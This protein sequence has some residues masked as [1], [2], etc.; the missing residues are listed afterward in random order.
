MGI[1]E[2]REREKLIRRDQILDAALNVFQKYGWSESTMDQV[3]DEAELAKGTLYLYFKDKEEIYAGL[4]ARGMLNLAERFK[5]IGNTVTPACI[6]MQ[7]IGEEY[8]RH[9]MDNSVYMASIHYCIHRLTQCDCESENEM[10]NLHEAG[11]KCLKAV[12]EIIQKGI[13]IGEFRKNLDP[14]QTAIIF[15]SF[16]DGIMTHQLWDERL[17]HR[18]WKVDMHATV[19]AGFRLLMKSIVTDKFI[20]L[21]EEY[22]DEQN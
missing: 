21:F 15:W 20:H 18:L 9:F 11:L 17:G 3:A 10:S 4:G 5:E 12:A 16:S 6:A 8:H 1:Q 2:R 22:H 19:W 7:K 13:D 14:M